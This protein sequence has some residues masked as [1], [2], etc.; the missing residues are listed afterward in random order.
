MT[1]PRGPG[2]LLRSYGRTR[3]RTLKPGRAD[4]MRAALPG[5]AIPPGPFDPQRAAPWA[6]ET[7]LEIGFGGGEH[8]AAQAARRPDV[9]LVGV[10]PFVNGVAS[11][12]RHV[13][14]RG[15]ANVRIHEGDGR[16]LMDWLPPA[17]LSRLFI[18]FPDPWPKARHRKRRL[19]DRAFVVRAA[20]VCAPGARVRLATDWADYGD[21]ILGAFSAGPAFRWTAERAIDWRAPPEDHV[22]TRYE[23][24]RLGDCAPLWLEFE[25][26]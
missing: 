18:L 6:R 12:V 13:T 16:E 20:E 9:L 15:L 5:L 1:A 7:W 4:L 23:E 21:Q 24:K 19:V 22:T 14:E 26:V 2:S 11:L 8:L 3:S 25:R 10:E 17:S